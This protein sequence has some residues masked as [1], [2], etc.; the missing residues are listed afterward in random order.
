MTSTNLPYADGFQGRT[1]G[2]GARESFGAGSECDFDGGDL[3]LNGVALTPSATELNYSKNIAANWPTKILGTPTITPGAEA[4]N[5]INVAVQLTDLYG[6]PLTESA[7]VEFYL[8]DDS[9]GDDYCAAVPDG[10]VAINTDGT[11]MKEIEADTHFV[12]WTEDDGQFDVDI[13]ESSD[14]TFYFVLVINGLLHIEA[15]DFD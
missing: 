12:V 10:D 15:V 14:K 4:G 1:H 3:K 11:I 7:K 13:G 5:V 9:G 2:S 8:S 6:D